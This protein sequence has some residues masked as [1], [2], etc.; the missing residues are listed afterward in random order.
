MKTIFFKLQFLFIY[1]LLAVLGSSLLCGLPLVGA[2]EGSSLVG[3][4]A[5]LLMV[6]AFVVEHGPWGVW[7]GMWL[8]LWSVD[9]V[10]MA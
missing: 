10:V 3:V 6:V 1:F 4:L 7:A 8:Q 2:I 9:S 5:G